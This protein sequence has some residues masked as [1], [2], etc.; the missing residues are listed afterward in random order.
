MFFFFFYNQLSSPWIISS[1]NFPAHTVILFYNC[2]NQY[3]SPRI[4]TTNKI[5]SWNRFECAVCG[6][7]HPQH[8]QTGSKSS[9]SSSIIYVRERGY[10][11]LDYVIFS[12]LPSSFYLISSDPVLASTSC[13]HTSSL[14]TLPLTSQTARLRNNSR[15]NWPFGTRVSHFYF[16]TSCM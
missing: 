8:T 13:Y 11:V 2:R 10:K 5:T 12:I 16:C 4:S 9:S 15:H 14:F 7:R 1:N 3:F 6:V